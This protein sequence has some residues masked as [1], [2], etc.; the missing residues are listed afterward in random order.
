MKKLLVFGA[1]MAFAASAM[2][3]KKEINGQWYS[4]H[5]LNPNASENAKPVSH[6]AGGGGGANIAYHG[7]DTLVAARVVPI[8]W[9][10]YWGSA[11]GSTERSTMVGFFEQFGTNPH[12]GVITQY[13]DT[14]YGGTRFIGGVTLTNSGDD[15]YDSSAPPTNVTDSNVQSEVKKYLTAKGYKAI[16]SHGVD[17]AIYEVFI[18]PTSFSSNGSSGS[19]GATGGVSLAYCAYHGSFKNTDGK[20]VKY[21]IEPYP[22]C[23]GCHASV[24]TSAVLDAQHFACHETR[25]A[26]TDPVN[27]WWANSGAEADDKCAWSPAPF[28]DGGYE[29]QYEWSNAVRGC[30]KQ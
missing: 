2:A 5:P 9:G 24:S 3:E 29:Y 1:V 25:E 20:I 30:V 14:V 27:A 8:F 6:E 11:P 22:S 28:I 15:W 17:Q 10:S 21:S 18:P 23:S 7:G 13:Y 19:C 4:F 16:D 12:Y 26:V